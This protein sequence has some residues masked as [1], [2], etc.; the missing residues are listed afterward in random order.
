MSGMVRGGPG[1]ALQMG[2][3]IANQEVSFLPGLQQSLLHG[4]QW[5]WRVLQILLYP[6]A[7]SLL[8][9]SL[10]EGAPDMSCCLLQQKLQMLNCCIRHKLAHEQKLN[11]P[12]LQSHSQSHSSQ[13]KFPETNSHSTDNSSTAQPTDSDSTP[14]KLAQS[15]DQS[16]EFITPVS[17]LVFAQ[18]EEDA[19][20]GSPGGSPSACGGSPGGSPS[21]SE[22]EFY[23]ALESQEQLSFSTRDDSTL[24]HRDSAVLEDREM[25]IDNE[26][27]SGKADEELEVKHNIFESSQPQAL[28]LGDSVESTKEA[29]SQ[30][31]EETHSWEE[32]PHEVVEPHLP[33]SR[34]DGDMA[35]ERVGAL[36]PCGDL[37][38]ITTGEP[39]YIPITQV[40]IKLSAGPILRPGVWKWD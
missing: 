13:L 24:D 17:S 3:W 12:H 14:A 39:L 2:E 16:A 7:L 37:V 36:Q 15:L 23:E 29:H 22:D 32:T 30:S 34:H 18:Q 5:N 20:G 38:L 8:L 19:C 27:V 28:G 10:P 35:S 25:D 1:A 33:P 40:H 4:L 6:K 31:I 11:T 26:V 21:G 9:P